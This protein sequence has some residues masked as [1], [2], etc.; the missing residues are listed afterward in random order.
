[1][2]THRYT[3]QVY[4]YYVHATNVCTDVYT[5]ISYN[6]QFSRTWIGFSFNE[7][8]NEWWTHTHTHTNMHA[9]KGDKERKWGSNEKPA[10]AKLERTAKIKRNEINF[11]W[12]FFNNSNNNNKTLF[13]GKDSME[14][15]SWPKCTC[16]Y[17]CCVCVYLCNMNAVTGTYIV[18]RSSGRWSGNRFLGFWRCGNRYRTLFHCCVKLLTKYLAN[19]TT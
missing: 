16:L 12:S 11:K 17:M 13:R 2:F 4:F 15:T 3:T 9:R 18:Y 1:M 5:C 19:S 8:C 14:I 6:I 7:R 10:R